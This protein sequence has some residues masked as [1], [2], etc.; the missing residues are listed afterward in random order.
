MESVIFTL[1]LA[2]ICFVIYKIFSS[3]PNPPTPIEPP[4]PP[5]PGPGIRIVDFG[6]Y[7]DPC[8]GGGGE[9]YMGIS[10]ILNS[11]VEE[12][13]KFETLV[14]YVLSGEQCGDFYRFQFFDFIIKKGEN[15]GG[16]NACTQGAYIE[17]GAKICKSYIINCEGDLVDWE[18]Y[19]IR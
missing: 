17:G 5:P 3:R 16:V 7:M 10:I 6:G 19:S 4:P 13:T 15:I 14:K 2:L 1:V 11:A 9:E 12:D 8:V 18:S